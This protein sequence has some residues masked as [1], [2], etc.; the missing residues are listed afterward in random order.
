MRTR[1]KGTQH[2]TIPETDE[3]GSDEQIKVRNVSQTYS[4]KQYVWRNRDMS[5]SPN[6]VAFLGIFAKGFR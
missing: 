2:V 5:K 1:T 4:A 6:D 3:S